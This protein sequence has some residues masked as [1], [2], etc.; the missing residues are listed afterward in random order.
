MH[1]MALRVR[2]L[3]SFPYSYFSFFDFHPRSSA[4][5]LSPS[6]VYSEGSASA[7]EPSESHAPCVTITP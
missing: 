6:V 3:P 4:A 7:L 1:R 2:T 5:L